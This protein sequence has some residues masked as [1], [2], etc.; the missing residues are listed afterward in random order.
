MTTT[1]PPKSSMSTVAPLGNTIR[2]SDSMHVLHVYWHFSTVLSIVKVGWM[3]A[4]QFYT[5]FHE[6]QIW[7]SRCRVFLNGHI[8]CAEKKYKRGEETYLVA[9]HDYFNIYFRLILTVYETYNL[10]K[11]GLI[12][13]SGREILKL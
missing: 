11:S 8:S 13:R 1:F 10:E 9:W 5:Q 12:D 7:K 4:C 6:C 3:G 2:K